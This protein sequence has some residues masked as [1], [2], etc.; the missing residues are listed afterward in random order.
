MRDNKNPESIQPS[1]RESETQRN[2]VTTTETPVHET[3]MTELNSNEESTYSVQQ[4]KPR[5][6]KQIIILSYDWFH[7][8]ISAFSTLII[9]LVTLLFMVITYK[10]LQKKSIIIEPFEVPSSLNQHGYTGKAIANKFIDQINIIKVAASTTMRSKQFTASWDTKESKIQTPGSSLLLDSVSQ[11]LRYHLGKDTIRILGEVTMRDN[12][13]HITTRVR[14]QPGKTVSGSLEELDLLLRRGAEHIYLSTQPY[15]LASYFFDI[16]KTRSLKIIRHIL[17]HPPTHDDAWAYNLWGLILFTQQDYEGAIS[18]YRNAT[19]IRTTSAEAEV[20]AYHN[21]GLALAEQ[22][23]YEEAI[24]KY[25]QALKLDKT[26][27]HAYTSWGLSLEKQDD[28]AGAMTKYQR[29]IDLTPK[30]VDAYF[31]WGVALH[32]QGNY[33]GA[34]MKY[35]QVVALEPQH[36]QAYNNWGRALAEQKKYAGAMGKYQQAIDN[37]SQARAEQGDCARTMTKCQQAIDDLDQKAVDVYFNW[38]NDLYAQREYVKA[39]AKFQKIIALKS[40]NI[41]AYFNIAHILGELGKPIEA[42]AQYEKIIAFDSQSEIAMAAKEAI[43]N[44]QNSM[45]ND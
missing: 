37:W 31:N 39:I 30:A 6:I 33:T 42:I 34:I 23:Q 29:A 5:R 22:Q 1:T 18:K 4:N 44:L 24:A 26:Y 28:Y 10:D 3:V 13:L 7:S 25:R 19:K 11:Y 38:G 15:I 45:P 36:V 35:E 40:E 2:D 43:H 27:A 41:N 17:R 16:D 14:G 32:A 20:H 21:W 12:L 8:S 9:P